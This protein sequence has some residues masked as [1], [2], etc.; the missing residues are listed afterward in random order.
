LIKR[1][2]APAPRRSDS[3]QIVSAVIAAAIELGP[4]TPLAAIAE[5]AGVGV[6]SLHRY[7]PTTAA[8][9]AEV[10]REMYRTLLRQV[11]E[12]TSRPDLPVAE[13]TLEICRVVLTE[14]RL[15]IAHR[16]RLTF[17]VPLEWSRDVAEAAYREILSEVVRYLERSLPVR[18]PDLEERVYVAFAAVRGAVLVSL[19]FPDLGP[20]E[21]RLI[22]QVSRCV[23]QTLGIGP[24]AP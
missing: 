19:M 8:L 6:A 14:P 2:P 17:D 22:A 4:D 3:Q 20:P 1:P 9:F 5:R 11:R 13:A 10:S 21:D 23:V 18:P 16:R 24:E 12:I 7:F 15:P